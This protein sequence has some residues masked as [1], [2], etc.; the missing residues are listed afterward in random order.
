MGLT[1]GL[2][3]CRKLRIYLGW[4]WTKRIGDETEV[5]YHGMNLADKCFEVD[6]ETTL[7]EILVRWPAK[8]LLE[9]NPRRRIQKI[10][11][12]R[13]IKEFETL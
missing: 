4:I 10:K 9:R 1:F 3:Y 7:H 8:P 11:A 5:A 12:E 6:H 13:K 2:F